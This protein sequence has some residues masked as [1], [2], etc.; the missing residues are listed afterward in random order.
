MTTWRELRESRVVRAGRASGTVVR[1]GLTDTM[2]ADVAVSLVLFYEHAL[3]VSRLADGLATALDR[4]PVFGGRLRTG[5]DRRL[6]IVCTDDGVPLSTYDVDES[7]PDAI[8][9]VALAGA[10][11]VDHVDAPKARVGGLPLLTIRVNRLAGGATALGISWHHAVADMQGFIV[12]LRAWSAAIEGSPPTDVDLAEDRDAYL[13]DVL[14]AQDSGRPGFRLPDADEAAAIQREFATALGANRTV[15]I[16]FSAVEVN[17]MR[18]KFGAE[19]GVRLSANDVLCAHVASTIRVLDNETEDRV[20]VLPVNIRKLLNLPSG[21][22]GNL[23]GEICLTCPA[24]GRPETLAGEIRT[25]VGDFVGSHLNIRTNREFLAAIGP[26]RLPDCVPVGF[27]PA[28]RTLSISNWSHFGGYDIPLAGQRPVLISPAANPPLPW[29]SWLVEGLDGVDYVST[30]VLPARLAARLRGATG[31]DALH[32]YR[33]PGDI[34][35]ALA[36][37]VRKL[38]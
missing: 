31:R 10:G 12:L 29:T 34:L 24:G 9:R 26:S 1:C 8:S 21:V 25:A 3:D 4:V 14:P 33:E 5:A 13:D 23:F 15:Q 20:L 18:Q 35:P 32:S 7:L 6:E 16:Y 37:A 11:L 38:V 19:A 17:R 30:V 27:D 28:R 22:V 36:T 2:L